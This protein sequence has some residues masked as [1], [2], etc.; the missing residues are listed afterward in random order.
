MAESVHTEASILIERPIEA[1][2]AFATDLAQMQRWRRGL[3][4]CGLLDGDT[5]AVGSRYAY[6][7]RFGGSTMDLAGEV[8]EWRP[9][10]SF[11]WV[12]TDPPFPA[13]GGLSCVAEG[14]GTRVTTFSDSQPSGA[15]RLFRPVMASIGRRQYRRELATLKGL[16]EASV[17]AE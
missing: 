5:M 8:T 11:R 2:F 3:R 16:L 6:L 12:A 14:T 17:P 7:V 10:T 1:V 15:M 13:S 4:E 9:P